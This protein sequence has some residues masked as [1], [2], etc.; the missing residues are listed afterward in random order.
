MNNQILIA[1][2]VKSIIWPPPPNPPDDDVT[3]VRP[4]SIERSFT[5]DNKDVY[6]KNESAVKSELISNLQSCSET[7]SSEQTALSSNVSFSAATMSTATTTS[8]QS[9][10]MVQS[11]QSGL[12]QETKSSIQSFTEHASSQNQSI[13]VYESQINPKGFIP[14]PFDEKLES[15]INNTKLANTIEE[16]SMSENFMKTHSKQAANFNEV[17]CVTSVGSDKPQIKSKLVPD[18]GTIQTLQQTT[19]KQAGTTSSVKSNF[20]KQTH[21]ETQEKKFSKNITGSMTEALT[22]APERPYSPLPS[23]Q[24]TDLLSVNTSHMQTLSETS[25]VHTQLNKL[26]PMEQQTKRDNP[27]KVDNKPF[28]VSNKK[29]VQSQT[30]V[31]QRSQKSNSQKNGSSKI[32][33]QKPSIVRGSLR[34]ALT[35]A[36]DRPYNSLGST[37]LQTYHISPYTETSPLPDFKSHSEVD[38]AFESCQLKEVNQ[39]VM[40]QNTKKMKCSSESRSAFKPVAKQVFPPPTP[41]EFANL[42]NLSTEV[43]PNHSNIEEQSRGKREL[44]KA[45]TESD[46]FT[47][48]TTSNMNI[49]GFSSVKTAQSYFE[50]RD[51]TET[52]TLTSVKPAFCTQMTTNMVR[53]NENASQIVSHSGSM[54]EYQNT[55]ASTINI[56]QPVHQGPSMQKDNL[57]YQCFQPV[58]DEA[59]RNSPIRSRPTTPSLINKP[60]PIIPHYQMNL[61]TVEHNAPKSQVYEP[62]STEA[63][64]SSTPMLRSRSPGQGLQTSNLKAHAPRIKEPTSQMQQGQHLAQANLKSDHE[65]SQRDFQT[66]VCSTFSAQRAPEQSVVYESRGSKS[67]HQI[68]KYDKGNLSFKEDSMINQN[69]GQKHMQSQ[70]VAEYGNTTVHTSKKTFEEFEQMQTAKVIEITKGGSISCDSYQKQID[71][72]IR[73][74]NISRQVFPPP[75]MNLQAIHETSPPNITNESVATANRPSEFYKPLP[76]ISGANQVPVCD[77]TP[78]TG[79]SVGGAARGKTFGVSSAPKRGRGVLNKA[80]LPG[81]RVPLCGS[82]NGNIR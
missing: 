61:V 76:S 51:K 56:R 49:H 38:N 31:E 72:N 64:R 54:P 60:A 32:N 11:V 69:Y 66:N 28:K 44:M 58:V 39:P 19:T 45:K 48:T 46:H 10:S 16:S 37:T 4:K 71:S 65:N 9:S 34:D 53:S 26:N 18:K 80:V 50:Q 22:I 68:E 5:H 23:V 52:A 70:N 21:L 74:S 77:P 17:Q 33:E 40:Q 6:S 67:G 24:A 7:V 2:N 42:S 78:S 30:T 3:D 82:C 75:V 12:I 63:S 57:P 79:S 29:T 41:E 14:L 27:P 1:Q 62:S 55:P 73:P 35:I 43:G 13:C 20:E 59:S 25:N 81:S 47:A 15:M 8:S 36:P